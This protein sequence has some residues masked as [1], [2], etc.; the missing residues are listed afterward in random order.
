MMSSFSISM[1]RSQLGLNPLDLSDDD[2]D[3]DDD[4]DD[5]GDDD[6][7]NKELH[8]SPKNSSNVSAVNS[9][10]ISAGLAAEFISDNFAQWR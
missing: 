5:D 8:Q 7:G 2:D 10:L 4:E 6:D 1:K 9:I 3:D